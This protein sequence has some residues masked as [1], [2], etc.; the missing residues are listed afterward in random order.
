MERTLSIIPN[1]QHRQ[2]PMSSQ[3][4]EG[5]QPAGLRPRQHLVFGPTVGPPMRR[6]VPSHLQH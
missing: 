2:S 3:T 1:S 4:D 6:L 5:A